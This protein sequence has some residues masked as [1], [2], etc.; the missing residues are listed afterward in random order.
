M[1]TNPISEGAFDAI[2][3]VAQQRAKL[4]ATIDQHQS[5][6]EALP[7]AKQLAVTHGVPVNTVR[8]ILRGQGYAGRPIT[9]A[10]KAS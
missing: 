8:Q 10:V 2:R 6:L 5:E 3:G 1:K 4:K 9:K 7:S